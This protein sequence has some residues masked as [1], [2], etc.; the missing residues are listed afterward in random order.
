MDGWMDGWI[1]LAGWNYIKIIDSVSENRHT[2][3]KSTYEVRRST[4]YSIYVCLQS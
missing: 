3:Y 2:V 4:V 1:S